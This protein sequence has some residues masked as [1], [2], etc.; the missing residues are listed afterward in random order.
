MTAAERPMC[1]TPPRTSVYSRARTWV[2]RR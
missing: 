2:K 1:R